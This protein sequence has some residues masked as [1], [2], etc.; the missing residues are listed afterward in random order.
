LGV[1]DDGDGLGY[2]IASFEAS[3]GPRLIEVKTT[4]A[5]KVLSFHVVPE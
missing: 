5:G 4:A 2:D 3:G 1:Q